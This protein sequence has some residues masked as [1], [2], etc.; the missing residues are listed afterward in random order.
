MPASD[1]TDDYSRFRQRRYG[2]TKPNKIK[3]KAIV[4]KPQ[5]ACPVS[6]PG[7][8]TGVA[9]SSEPAGGSSARAVGEGIGV[10]V[11][12]GGNKDIS[13][14]GVG[15]M[16]VTLSS[17]GTGGYGSVGSSVGIGVRVGGTGVGGGWVGTSVGGRLV[18][19]E[20]GGCSVGV[21]PGMVEVG[22]TIGTLVTSWVVTATSGTHP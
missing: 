22:K 6:S 19:S 11:G 15:N 1:A 10:S 2:R 5:I 13:S 9:I 16:G 8:S 21:S 18:G 7:S 4:G 3:T 14:V 17:V 12:N 20:V